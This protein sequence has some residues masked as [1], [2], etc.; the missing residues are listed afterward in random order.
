MSHS[1][2]PIRPPDAAAP[3][4]LVADPL[5]VQLA[6][7]VSAGQTLE[8]LTRPLLEMLEAV[9]GLE[10]TYLTTI[11][12]D[13]GLQHIL[14]AR[15]SRRLTIPEGLSVPWGDTLCK[16]ALDENRPYTS[17]V[18]SC[19]ADSDAAA[20]LGI[21]TYV[22]T[23]VHAGDGGLYGTLCA[24]SSD[25]L[26]LAPGAQKILGLFARLIGQHVERERMFE[27]LRKANAELAASALLDS[28]TGLP[29]RRFLA[30]ELQ[31]ILARA[32]REESSV[33]VA[34][35]D[36]D[37]FKAINDT[38]GHE[39]GDQLLDAVGRRLSGS[40]RAG[41]FVARIGGDEFVVLAPVPRATAMSAGEAIRRALE[42]R[43][44]APYQLDS[45]LV[46]QCGASV[47]VAIGGEDPSA[48]DALLNAAD[49][50][51]YESKR[52]RRRVAVD[53]SAAPGGTA[54]T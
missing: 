7:S 2:V 53:G 54:T 15:N 16:R 22:S 38:H 6:D 3:G 40:L 1:A 17:D 47:G 30:L 41:D 10:S 50:A 5:L 24:A 51:M 26:A 25:R 9:T 27:K 19:W 23:P 44:G 52:A 4:L 42:E 14:Y 18:A 45:L 20:E 43:M 21:N 46:D 8:E 29:N 28:V 11:D 13:A 34:F 37:G 35:L 49:A 39:A 32:A 48:G 33:V 12:L 36:L 31:R